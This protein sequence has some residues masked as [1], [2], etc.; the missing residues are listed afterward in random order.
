MQLRREKKEPSRTHE[1]IARRGVGVV[2]SRT[3]TGM[4]VPQRIGTL[5]TSLASG[6]I[7]LKGRQRVFNENSG[8]R[9]SCH[10]KTN[11]F[12]RCLEVLGEPRE[13]W[14]PRHLVTKSRKKGREHQ[15]QERG[16]VDCS[17]G[18]FGSENSTALWPSVNEWEVLHVD[19]PESD[20]DVPLMHSQDQYGSWHCQ[21]TVS[22]AGVRVSRHGQHGDQLLP[23]NSNLRLY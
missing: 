23:I 1:E 17:P 13:H 9:R 22:D 5:G 4:A 20:G 18:L 2:N 11:H 19:A 6:R 21:D 10:D 15:G 3:D 14:T 16:H 8:D 12:R 7:D